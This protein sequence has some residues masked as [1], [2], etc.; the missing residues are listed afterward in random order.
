MSFPALLEVPDA[1][2]ARRR[3]NCNIDALNILAHCHFFLSQRQASQLI[4]SGCINTQGVTSHVIFTWSILI[5]F[6]KML[7]GY[8]VVTKLLMLLYD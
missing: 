1:Q 2:K 3:T 6:V 8:L 5:E 7:S 4:C